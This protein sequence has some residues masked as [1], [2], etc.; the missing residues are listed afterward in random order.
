MRGNL[1]KLHT[2]KD[3]RPVCVAATIVK[4]FSI[5]ADGIEVAQIRGNYRSL[6]KIPLQVEAREISVRWLATN[7]AERV[8][9]FSADFLC[10]E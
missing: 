10:A 7:G 1:R 5:Y 9:L 8:H 6:V 4:D 3:F 2:G